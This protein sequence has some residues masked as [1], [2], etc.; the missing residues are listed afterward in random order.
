MK[1]QVVLITGASGGL[2]TSVVRAFRDAGATVAASS[3][4]SPEFPADLLDPAQAK[5]LVDRVSG[6]FGRIDA[7][8]H[9]AGGFV[10]GAVHETDDATWNQ[11]MNVNLRSAFHMFR[12]VLPHMRAAGR[13]RIV[14]IGSRAA[15]DLPPGI[16]AYAA[17]KAALVSL[18][19]SISLENKQLGIT[20]NAI[21]PSTIGAQVSPETIASL[22]LYLVSDAA[23]QITGVA[24]PC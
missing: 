22:A 17:S 13:G 19:R 3:R 21:L 5:A 16:A 8:V 23:A 9:L 1:G 18:V 11:M 2:G 20:A 6:R 4:K 24:I 7:L 12:A 10:G 14:A 15:V